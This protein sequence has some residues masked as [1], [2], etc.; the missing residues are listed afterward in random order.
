MLDCVNCN[1]ETK[2]RK[3]CM[4]FVGVEFAPHTFHRHRLRLIPSE[5]KKFL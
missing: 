5:R 1:V 3:I 4:E 2:P